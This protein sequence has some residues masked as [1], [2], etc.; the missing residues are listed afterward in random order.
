MEKKKVIAY[1]HTHWDREWYHTKED[2]NI[3]L[4]EVFDEVL[5]ELEMGFAPSFYFD[6]QTC[7]LED[8]LK[9]RPEKLEQ[10]KK[11]IE[12]KKLFVGPFFVS[13]DS[14]LT[15]AKCLE[16]NLEIGLKYARSLGAEDF[17]GYM[18]D[19]F[20]HSYEITKILS[21]FNIDKAIVWR[22]TGN[23][24]A[25]FIYNGINTTRLV[26]GYFIDTLHSGLP[27][28]KQA[29]ALE[30]LLDKIAVYST[31]T[32][33]LPLGADHLKI[34]KNAN[35]KI[36]QIN[37]HLKGYEIEL[38]NPFE[39]F[40]RVEFK[41]I[42]NCEF[43]DNSA[44]YTL[45]GV[46]SSRIHQKIQNANLQWELNEIAMPLNSALNSGYDATLEYGA[47]VLIKNHAHDSIYGCSLDEVNNQVQAR[48]EKVSQILN[49]VKKR[50]M[51][52][53]P[54]LKKN[55]IGVYNL[56]N[57]NFSG[58]I[59]FKSE[60]KIKNTQIVGKTKGFPDS[61]LYDCGKI[62]VTEDFRILYTQIAEVKGLKEGSYSTIE[63]EIPIKK[64]KITQNLIENDFI[65]IS[66]KNGEFIIEDKLRKKV[67]KNTFSISDVGD[68]GDSY[69][70]APASKPE[71][72]PLLK[73]KIIENG[74]IRSI[75]RAYFKDIELDIMLYNN[76]KNVEFEA[77]INNKKKN[78]K[79]RINF[80]LEN[81]VNKTI[82]EDLITQ[83]EREIDCDYSLFENLP[84]M[85][86]V[87]LKTN[88]YPLQRWVWAQN[89]GI[90]TKGLNEY[91]VY[92]NSLSITLLRATG[93]I[94]NPK[95]A[96]R[97]IPAG[98][99]LLTPNLQCLGK[100]TLNFAVS[101]CA[102]NECKN[103]ADEFYGKVVIR[104]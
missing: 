99:P 26:E 47:K 25:D 64:T 93:V 42:R 73:T 71:I 78:H 7:A 23:I 2:F 54:T 8:Y 51:L 70:F 27:V 59:E 41:K 48:F 86:P 100:L 88:S 97:S 45:P 81:P 43:L 82:A 35:E 12:A 15:S 102:L 3:R 18:S 39:Y 20:G 11:L 52:N 69:N 57:T 22:G 5:Y 34:L 28:E 103:I 61:L 66:I 13:A 53:L 98:P 101:F 92:K 32:L 65:K 38:S 1:L 4:L 40:K 76:S 10:V 14:F 63:A 72:L 37:L 49:G 30:N 67:L 84:A 31:S 36:A 6:G 17:L 96:A 16:K 29:L 91:E 89:L 55:E 80:N 60:Y 74:V 68:N 21:K 24:E 62:P 94:S 104:G 87:E 19:A 58:V 46:Y 85:R 95:N 79:L 44:N 50:I 9:F 56:S 83:V 33:L 77:R 90:F 75:L